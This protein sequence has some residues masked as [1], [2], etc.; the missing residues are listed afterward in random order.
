MCWCLGTVRAVKSGTCDPVCVPVSSY[1][2]H[3][4]AKRTARSVLDR[5]TSAGKLWWPDEELGQRKHVCGRVG[6]NATLRWW[7]MSTRVGR[8][9]LHEAEPL[10]IAGDSPF[11]ICLLARVG[12]V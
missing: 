2:D 11:H 5:L 6:A 10:P 3:C 1:S 7:C 8:E 9:C 4:R 12:A